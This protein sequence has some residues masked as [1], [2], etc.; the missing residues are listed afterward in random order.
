MPMRRSDPKSKSASDH[1]D[2]LDLDLPAVTEANAPIAH[3]APSATLV[4]AHARQLLRS[5]RPEQWVQ[6][7]RLMHPERF[8]L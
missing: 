3:P 5:V 6:R 7:D 8:V 4:Y 2:G 1:L